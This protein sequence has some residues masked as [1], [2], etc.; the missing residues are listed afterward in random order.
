MSRLKF[1]NTVFGRLNQNII[2]F[3]LF[4]LFFGNCFSQKQ[5]TTDLYKKIKKI[6][7]KKRFTSLLYNSIFVEPCPEVYSATPDAIEKIVKENKKE[8]QKIIRTIHI[9]VYSPFGRK[10]GES[11]PK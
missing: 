1:K 6:A 10:V 5:D 2:L 4:F 11:I 3:F 9:T 8:Q 7:Y